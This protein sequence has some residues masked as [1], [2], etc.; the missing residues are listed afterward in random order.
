MDV[1]RKGWPLAVLLACAAITRP[2]GSGAV[3]PTELQQQ[4]AAKLRVVEGYGRMPLAFEPN[5]GQAD[6]RVQFLSRGQG[7]TLFLTQEEAVFS[8]RRGATDPAQAQTASFSMRLVRGRAA[9]RVSS[10]EKL[11]GRANY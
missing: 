4:T 5:L 2:A 8:L 9:A 3:A 11:S 10:E 1:A 6:S 7:Y